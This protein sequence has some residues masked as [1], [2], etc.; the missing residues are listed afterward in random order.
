MRLSARIRAQNFRTQI[1]SKL[2][3]FKATS[4][5]STKQKTENMPGKEKSKSKLK[6]PKAKAAAVN[7]VVDKAESKKA[8]TPLKKNKAKGKKKS[9]AA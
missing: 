6:S 7:V 3:F 1:P 2:Y 5:F 4:G 9:V 8:T